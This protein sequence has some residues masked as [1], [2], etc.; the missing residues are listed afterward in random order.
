MN[1]NNMANIL[2]VEDESIVALELESRLIHLGYSIC[3]VAASV[4]DAINITVSQ[5]PDIILMDINIKG[6]IDGV[7]TAEKIKEIIN[8]I[9]RRN[10]AVMRRDYPSLFHEK[11]RGANFKAL[12]C[13]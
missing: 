12:T 13:C 6:P 2:I 3:G 5:K 1:K 10:F 9:W 4:A 11:G 7:E 8:I